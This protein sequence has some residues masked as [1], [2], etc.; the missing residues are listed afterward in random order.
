VKYYAVR[1][2]KEGPKVYNTWKQCEDAVKG[3]KGAKFKSFASW[4]DAINYAAST[5]EVLESYP[6]GHHIAVD[7]SSSIKENFWE[8]QMVWTDTLEPIYGSPVYKDGTN[9]TGEVLGLCYAVKYRSENNLD[10]NIYT[11]SMTAISA[12]EKGSYNMKSS[13]ISE[14]SKLMISS[15]LLE[16]K[17][18]DKTKIIHY[19]NKLIGIEIPADFNRK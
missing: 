11:D 14:G 16:I 2:G 1:Y 8:F 5:E 4:Q 3:Y 6:E 17:D 12:V 19:N 15:I 13:L 10:C 9:N 18:M 7:A